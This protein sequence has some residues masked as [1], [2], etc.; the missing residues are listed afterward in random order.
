M[1]RGHREWRKSIKKHKRRWATW[2][3]RGEHI[4]ED[5]SNCQRSSSFCKRDSV[6]WTRRREAGSSGSP[7]IRMI[8][9]TLKKDRATMCSDITLATLGKAEYCEIN[10]GLVWEKINELTKNV[11]LLLQRVSILEMRNKTFRKLNDRLAGDRTE[12]HNFDESFA[13]RGYGIRTCFDLVSMKRVALLQCIWL[14]LCIGLF[15]G[16]AIP[17]FLIAWDNENATWKSEKK[18]HTIDYETETFN[19]QYEMPYIYIIFEVGLSHDENKNWSFQEQINYTLEEMLESQKYFVNK[20]GFMYM[21]SIQTN[22]EDMKSSYSD[23]E[24]VALYKED[25][26]YEESFLGYFRLKPLNPVPGKS[27]TQFWLSIDTINLTGVDFIDGFY[28]FIGRELS[29]VS[30]KNFVWLNTELAVQ[31]KAWLSFSI[32]Y[33]SKVTRMMNNMDLEVFE[34]IL[35]WWES[36]SYKKNSSKNGIVDIQITTDLK[37]EHWQEYVEYGYWDWL[38]AIGGLL[39][40]CSFVFLQVGYLITLTEGDDYTMGILPELSFTF[41]NLE[42]VQLF[43]EFY[44]DLGATLN[45]VDVYFGENSNKPEE[46]PS[47]SYELDSMSC[48]SN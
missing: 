10:D 16:V 23:I 48:V 41:S 7:T 11:E 8:R 34:S 44:E 42:M 40:F 47:E 4:A 15:I 26:V 36:T 25:W 28:I 13:K 6:L 29:S 24:A 18:H 2:S 1:P 27:W 39:S 46:T 31:E 20:T 19:Y 12:K 22:F 35:T 17:L 37:V 3:T 14:I 45:E 30:F 21:D 33:T 9:E 43:K 5:R 32:D 38:A